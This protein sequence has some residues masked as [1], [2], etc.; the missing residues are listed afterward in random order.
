MNELLE[1]TIVEIK[2]AKEMLR[3]LFEEEL[4]EEE[5]VEID[6]LTPEEEQVLRMRFGIA[7]ALKG[8]LDNNIYRKEDQG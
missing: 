4:T 6:S 2:R 8:S 1:E 7:E 5:I 3:I